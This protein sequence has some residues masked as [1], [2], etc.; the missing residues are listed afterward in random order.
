M[1]EFSFVATDFSSLI[2]ITGYV[3]CCDM[4]ICVT[5]NLTWRISILFQFLSRPSFLLSR[6]NSINLQLLLSQKKT[7]LSR[8]R[9]CIQF[10]TMSQHEFLCCHSSFI[11]IQILVVI[12][13]SLSQHNSP[14]PHVLFVTIEIIFVAT[15]SCLLFAVNSECYVATEFSLFQH[16]CFL[17]LVPC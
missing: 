16:K 8:Q 2:L 5:K 4:E 11:A 13:N 7:S 17:E 15:K 9:F 1:T 10:F 12:E 6:Q 14:Q 3:V